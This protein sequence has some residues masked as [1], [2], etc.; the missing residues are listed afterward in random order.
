MKNMKFRFIREAEQ[1]LDDAA[2]YY[3]KQ[4]TGLERDFIIEIEQCVKEIIAFPEAWPPFFAKVRRHTPKRFPYRVC[5]VITPDEII[6]VAVE[7]TS[8]NPKYWVDRLKDIT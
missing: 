2:T 4:V 8:Q 3:N 1:E 7:H 5:Y 6:G